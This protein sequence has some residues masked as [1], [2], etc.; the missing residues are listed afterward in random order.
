M[1][2]LHEAVRDTE[3]DDRFRYLGNDGFWWVSAQDLRGRIEEG[4]VLD[5][6]CPGRDD[7]TMSGRSPDVAT[8]E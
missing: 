1:E 3:R 7:L 2:I 4:R 5:L 6:N 8:G